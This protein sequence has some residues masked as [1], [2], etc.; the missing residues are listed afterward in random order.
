MCVCGVCVSH[1]VLAP[2]Q[3][4]S[5]AIDGRAQEVQAVVSDAKVQISKPEHE[6]V[7]AK[8]CGREIVCVGIGGRGHSIL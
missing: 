2:Q 3:V 4:E 1:L 5:S 6:P 8:G 7:W